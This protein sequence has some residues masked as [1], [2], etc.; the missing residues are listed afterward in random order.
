[1]KKAGMMRI[2]DLLFIAL[3]LLFVVTLITAAIAAVRG[4]RAQALRVLR[5]LAFGVA[6]YMAIV[7]V[8]SAMTKPRMVIEGEPQCNDDWCIAVDG[9]RT[10]PN[11]SSEDY[12]VTLRVYS[13]ALRVTQR[14]YGA[15]VY[16]KD[17][18]GRKFYPEIDPNQP[19]LS[20]QLGPGELVITHRTFQLPQ[21][22][23]DVSL[24]VAH[25][26]FPGCFV[27]G[28][29]DWLHAQDFVPMQ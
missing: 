27:I 25:G 5:R 19:P 2:F 13:R 20:V 4:R 17:S 14:E 9:A 1:L 26:G 8:V 11:G 28:E 18:Q 10:F 6:I 7:L 29:N 12:D 15:S 22:A 23:H 3:V 21:G 24:I 16:L